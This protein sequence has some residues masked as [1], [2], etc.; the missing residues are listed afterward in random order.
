MRRCAAHDVL[1][2]QV[3]IFGVLGQLAEVRTDALT[4]STVEL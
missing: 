2:G 3:G 1:V 4:T